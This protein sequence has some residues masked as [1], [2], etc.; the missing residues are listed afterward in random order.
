M[1]RK[2]VRNWY[3]WKAEY[4]K[5]NFILSSYLVDRQSFKSSIQKKGAERVHSVHFLCQRVALSLCQ[6]RLN[7]NFHNPRQKPLLNSQPNNTGTSR[8]IS[9]QHRHKTN[10]LTWQPT[11][12]LFRTFERITFPS[13]SSPRPSMFFRVSPVLRSPLTSFC[14]LFICNLQTIQAQTGKEKTQTAPL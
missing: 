14:V 2:L 5:N 3:C 6:Q 7:S 11:I 4:W 8:Q 1:R 10:S 13:P 12:R 9:N